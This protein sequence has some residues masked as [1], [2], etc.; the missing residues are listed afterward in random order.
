MALTSSDLDTSTFWMAHIPRSFSMIPFVSSAAGR[1]ISMA[2]TF[3][4]WRANNTEVAL[5]LPHPGPTDPAPVTIA[6]LFFNRSTILGTSI[7]NSKFRRQ[8]IIEKGDCEGKKKYSLSNNLIF[9]E[10]D[11]FER[12]ALNYF[13]SLNVSERGEDPQYHSLFEII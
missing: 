10:E 12:A 1:L 6:T 9:V 13:Y 3:A 5:P 8:P 7:H 2:K 4:P 11:M